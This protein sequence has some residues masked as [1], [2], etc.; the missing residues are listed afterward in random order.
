MAQHAANDAVWRVVG[1]LVGLVIEDEIL[2]LVLEHNIHEAC[3]QTIQLLGLKTG[4]RLSRMNCIA[5]QT[6]NVL[7]GHAMGCESEAHFGPSDL[8]VEF[9]QPQTI[10]ICP[11]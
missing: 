9:R 10:L 4:A 3:E 5:N 8:A 7:C 11:T 1:Q 2:A 6:V